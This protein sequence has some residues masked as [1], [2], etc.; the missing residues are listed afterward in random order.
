MNGARSST[1]WSKSLVV[2]GVLAAAGLAGYAVSYLV[3]L[4]S[5]GS[6]GFVPT[7][8]GDRDGTP[9]TLATVLAG[10]ALLYAFAFLPVAVAVTVRR[11]RAAS[12]A[13]IIAAC[14]A[15]VSSVVEIVN[16]L[17]VFAAGIFPGDL[18]SIP[19]DVL[20]RLIQMDA[21]RFLALDVAG[22]TLVYLAFAVYALVEWRE[23]RRPAYLIATSIVLFIVNVPFLRFAPKAAVVLMAASILAM[24]P[25]AVWLGRTAASE[26][27]GVP[28]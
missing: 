7:S 26:T 4:P 3:A 17:P 13:S 16:N 12:S 1:V 15:G 10:F 24:A 19:A 28:S 22:F 5:V 9:S 21:I 8:L 20:L 6:G 23:S 2:L 14:L 18:Q 25:V 27:V 11:Y